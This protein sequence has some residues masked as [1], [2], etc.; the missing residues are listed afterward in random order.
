[1]LCLFA[2]AP[3]DHPAAGARPATLADRAPGA[4]HPMFHAVTRDI[5]VTVEPTYL[6]NDS[7]P[8]E[9]RFVWA[10]HVTIANRGGVG[11]QLLSR[12]WLITDAHGLRREVSGRGVVGQ[13]PTIPPGGSFEYTSGCPLTTPSG[14]MVGTYRMVSETGDVFDVDIPAFSLDTPDADRVLN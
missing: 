10:Y 2:D 4:I 6:P 9:N 1:M 11:V 13:Q 3:Y 8:D 14:F 5:V 12:E 7:D